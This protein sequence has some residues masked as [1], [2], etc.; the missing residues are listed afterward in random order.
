M[1][2]EIATE[3]EDLIIDVAEIEL[4]AHTCILF[5]YRPSKHALCLL[6]IRLRRF[7]LRK[8]AH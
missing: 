2:L 4:S 6:S 1:A 7:S 5:A 8:F 3:F